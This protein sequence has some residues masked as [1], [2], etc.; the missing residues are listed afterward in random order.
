MI[1][2]A[3]LGGSLAR[4]LHLK[5]GLSGVLEGFFRSYLNDRKAG[6]TL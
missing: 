2:V 5:E 1:T 6:K 3:F 4:V